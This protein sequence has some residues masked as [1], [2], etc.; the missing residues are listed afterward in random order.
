MIMNKEN[1]MIRKK[2]V[3]MVIIMIILSSGCKEK[4]EQKVVETR[5]DFKPQGLVLFTLGDVTVGGK[6]VKAG[7]TI[8][9]EESL[10]TGKKSACDL[11]ITGLDSDVTVRLR[12]N[13]DFA[14]AGFVKQDVKNLQM[15][16]LTGKV[17]VSTQKL[18]T[19]ESVETIT[20]TAVV[21]VRGTKYEVEVGKD[22]SSSISVLEGR[23]AAKIIILEIEALPDDVKE[24]SITL[25][26]LDAYLME[27]ELV[28]ESGYTSTVTKKYADKVLKDT[29]IGDIIKNADKAQLT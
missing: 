12:E 25:K 11:Q 4:E 13:S 8:Q 3:M 2:F 19:K 14:L 7:D 15:K 22:L 1:K 27:K 24:N 23:V 10:K 18:N 26:K 6:Q 16:I 9:D 29:R 28:I 17:L 20:P 5:P 21:G